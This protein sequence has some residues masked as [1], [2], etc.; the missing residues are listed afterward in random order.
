MGNRGTNKGKMI[1]NYDPA[2]DIATTKAIQEQ[3][4][5]IEYIKQK[6]IEDMAIKKNITIK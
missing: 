4:D 1:Y 2:V 5:L 6:M 3:I